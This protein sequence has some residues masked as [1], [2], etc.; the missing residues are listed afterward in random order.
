[1]AINQIDSSDEVSST[2]P[3]PIFSIQEE[4]SI[5]P[6]IPQPCVEIQVLA[7]KFEKPI[8][9]ITFIDTGAQQTMMDPYILPQEYWKKEVD[10]FVAADGKIFRTDLVTHAPI[11]IKF[12][13]DCI[14]WTKVIGSKLPDRDL[15]IGMDVYTTASK[16][17]LH[18]TGIKFKRNFKP[19]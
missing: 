3:I 2:S 16:L 1:M 5:R 11:G 4:P 18:S 9:V 10:Y 17:Q 19:F 7:N 13:P 15:L 8:K 12:F 6:A 14:I